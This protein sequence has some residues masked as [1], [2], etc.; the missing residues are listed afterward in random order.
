MNMQPV[1][2]SVLFRG[3]LENPVSSAVV[4]KQNSP[5]FPYFPLP[6][7]HGDRP[8]YCTKIPDPYGG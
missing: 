8:G 2:Y 7:Y 3:I 5:A 1:K 6:E 4:L